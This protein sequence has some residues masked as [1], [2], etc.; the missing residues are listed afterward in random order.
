MQYLRT[1]RIDVTTTAA[2]KRINK[3]SFDIDFPEAAKLTTQEFSD[4]LVKKMWDIYDVD[5]DGR[6]NRREVC[7]FTKDILAYTGKKYN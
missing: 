5:R 3:M 2:E 7:Q 4:L 6:L 1:K